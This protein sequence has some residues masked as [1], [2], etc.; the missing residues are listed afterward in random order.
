MRPV[1]LLHLWH[2]C[3]LDAPTVAV[4]WTWFVSLAF[5]VSPPPTLYVAMFFGVWGLYIVD[6]LLDASPIPGLSPRDTLQQRHQFHL[7]HRRWMCVLFL[8][9]VVTCASFAI[10]MPLVLIFSYLI[11]I[12][13][14]GLYF[15]F[16]HL[17]VQAKAPKELVVGIFFAAAAFIPSLKVSFASASNALLFAALCTLN[18]LFIK[19]WESES[20]YRPQLFAAAL[21]T[22]CVVQAIVSDDAARMLPLC[23]IASTAFYMI[24]NALR[25]RIDSLTLRASVDFSL[26]TPLFFYVATALGT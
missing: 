1:K 12:A 23:M 9:C 13:L 3:S 6:R 4:V 20:R 26:L 22:I 25:D 2:L 11:V 15:A 18:G 7:K 24:L 17:Q 5:A 21:A 8:F 10:L 14:L 19:A 16:V